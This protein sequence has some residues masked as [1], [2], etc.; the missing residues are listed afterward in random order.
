ME[1]GDWRRSL[2]PGTIAARKTF[3]ASVP[4]SDS[5]PIRIR[6]AVSDNAADVMFPHA[7]RALFLGLVVLFAAPLPADDLSE[8]VSNILADFEWP[9]ALRLPIGVTPQGTLIWCLVDP[10]ALRP[11]EGVTRVV[12][13]AGLDGDPQTVEALR[14]HRRSPLLGRDLP[15]RYARAWIPL[16]HP[17][18][19]RACRESQAQ[20]RPLSFPP[21]GSAYNTAGEVEAAILTRFLAWYAPDAVLEITSADDPDYERTLRDRQVVRNPRSLAAS[22]AGGEPSKLAIRGA[23]LPVRLLALEREALDPL[24]RAYTNLDSFGPEVHEPSPTARR[25]LERIR[26]PPLD[27]A[28]RLLAHYGDRLT[29]VMYQPALAVMARLTYGDL[30][31]EPAHQQTVARILEP[32]LS[33]ERAALDDKSGGSHFAGHLVFAAWAQRTGDPRAVELVRRAADRA[34]DAQGRPREAMPTHNE[35]SDAVFMAC[36][37]LT[38]AGRLTGEA[39]YVEMAGRHLEFMQR[40]CLRDDGLYRH[41]P[42]CEAPWGRG[43]GFPALGLAL[44]LTDLEEILQRP[45]DAADGEDPL[46]ASAVRVHA[47][48]LSAL[49]AHLLA[50]LPHQDPTGMWRQVIDHPGAYRELT[51]TCMMTFALARGVRRGWIDPAVARP[52][53][54]RAWPALALRIFDDGV[55]L[56]V[57]TG[58][59][60]Q[61]TLQDYLDREAIWGRDERGGAM[62]LLAALEIEELRRSSRREHKTGA[63]PRTPAGRPALPERSAPP[64]FGRPLAPDDAPLALPVR[65]TDLR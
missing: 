3:A 14:A 42:L 13:V 6:S 47:Q 19:W 53:L 1:R 22:L 48:M 55:L 8:E 28:G 38:A 30:T 52:A 36:P 49:R 64:A 57:C 2:F 50:L 23:W 27:V 40:L 44:A 9:G 54:D 51:A 5:L 26:R 16:A 59:G 65:R 25:A 34:F 11:V 39:R 58:T 10:A 62:A 17:D 33:G 15:G 20:P 41:S 7:C 45:P 4:F 35:M 24:T 43:N 61:Q 21:T 12:I 60:K 18:A 31:D 46:R 29:V 37:L 56:D 63:A 32:Y